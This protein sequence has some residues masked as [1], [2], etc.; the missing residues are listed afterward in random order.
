MPAVYRAAVVE[1]KD[2]V[3]AVRALLRSY[4]FVHQPTT[5]VANAN[6]IQFVR[7]ELTVEIVAAPPGKETLARR[8]VDAVEGG[9]S[10]RPDRVAVLFDP[11]G[12]LP[13]KRFGFF[14]RDFEAARERRAGPMKLADHGEYV[15][16]V[17]NREARIIPAPW[18]WRD[19]P[20]Y[21]DLPEVSCLERVLIAGILQ[22]TVEGELRDWA[23]AATTS[24]NELIPTHGYKRAFRIWNAIIKPGAESF[25]DALLQEA[26]T[27]DAVLLALKQT[28]AARALERLLAP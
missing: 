15:V 25:V 13:A 10:T 4:E 20:S 12:D 3:A 17:R 11:D 19:Q 27:R 8:T 6:R 22:S 24:L 23:L 18:C 28:D 26:D 14:V 2:D 7:G 5:V 21:D 1:G 9:S 16:R